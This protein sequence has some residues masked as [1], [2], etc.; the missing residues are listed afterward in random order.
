MY[1]AI[2]LSVLNR[3]RPIV[4]E[5]SSPDF[6]SRNTCRRL[7]PPSFAAV[8]SQLFMPDDLTPAQEAKGKLRPVSHFPVINAEKHHAEIRTD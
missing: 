7:I 2:W 8:A 6:Q 4:T 3:R 5:P 1:S